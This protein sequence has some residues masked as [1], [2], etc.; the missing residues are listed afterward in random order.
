MI[1][2]DETKNPKLTSIET[3]VRHSR[4]HYFEIVLRMNDSTSPNITINAEINKDSQVMGRPKQIIGHVSKQTLKRLTSG[5]TA[6]NNLI[7]RKYPT[8]LNS[9]VRLLRIS[10]SPI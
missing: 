7:M 9:A 10:V 1:P 4:L 5:M 6:I 2:E 8:E 3:M